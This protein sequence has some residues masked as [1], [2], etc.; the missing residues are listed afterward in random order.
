MDESTKMFIAY[1][2]LVLG[3]PLIAAKLLWCVPASITAS[4]FTRVAGRLDVFMD[5]LAEGFLSFLL[6][7]QSFELLQLTV[8]WQVPLILILVTWLWNY[9]RPEGLRL[10]PSVLGIVAGI[11][12][13]PGGL[14]YPR[15]PLFDGR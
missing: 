8:T 11:V 1:G 6:S 5:A 13:C 4:V 7:R 14:V 15:L 9:L 3:I 2:S 12:L 10:F